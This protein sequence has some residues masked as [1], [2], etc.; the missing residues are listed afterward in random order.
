MDS[1]N[2]MLAV[3]RG[4]VPWHALNTEGLD[5]VAKAMVGQFRL[6]GFPH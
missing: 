1:A 5:V 6:C 3:V 2:R 4:E